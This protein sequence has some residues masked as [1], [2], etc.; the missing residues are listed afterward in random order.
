MEICWSV[1]LRVGR[2][3]VNL[4]AGTDFFENGLCFYCH[5]AKRDL[6]EYLEFHSET[7]QSWAAKDKKLQDFPEPINALAVNYYHKD[8]RLE[9]VAREVGW[10]GK[11]EILKFTIA[12]NTELMNQLGMR[13]LMAEDG[14]VKRLAWEGS[15]PP[16]TLFQQVAQKLNLGIPLKTSK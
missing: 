9:D 12:G 6:H 3:N 2:R 7:E 5:L 13:A 11:L 4:V 8:L 15:A 1:H 14:T 10:E 16:D